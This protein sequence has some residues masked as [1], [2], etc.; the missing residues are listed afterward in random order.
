MQK[1]ERESKGE[2]KVIW[3]GRQR[4]KKSGQKSHILKINEIV[5]VSHP[6]SSLFL[7]CVSHP[8]FS[9][10]THLNDI[11]F[12]KPIGRQKGTIKRPLIAIRRKRH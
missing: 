2:K 3:S 6:E 12:F 9:V 10:L 4:N 11:V 7:P 5:D 1:T 8:I